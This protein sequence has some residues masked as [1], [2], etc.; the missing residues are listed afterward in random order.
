M[1]ISVRLVPRAAREEV[2]GEREGA[3][4]VRVTA[5]PVEGAANRALRKLLARRLGVAQGAV[6][7]A[8]GQRSRTKTVRVAGLTAAQVLKRLR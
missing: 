6:E 8:A 2:A 7:I 1:R 5:P 4:L 3:L